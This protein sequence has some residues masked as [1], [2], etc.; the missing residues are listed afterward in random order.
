MLELKGWTTGGV[1]FTKI[2]RVGPWSV[3]NQGNP[4][5]DRSVFSSHFVR[6][7]RPEHTK[8]AELKL[9]FEKVIQV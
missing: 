3:W 2:G 7:S 1:A 8:K 6:V 5:V 9:N 4:L